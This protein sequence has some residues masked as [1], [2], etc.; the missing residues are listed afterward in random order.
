MKPLN[1]FAASTLL[2]GLSQG[3]ATNPQTQ[4]PAPLAKKPLEDLEINADSG[5]TCNKEGTH[6][7]ASGH[8]HVKQGA[9]E[10]TCHHLDVTFSRTDHGMQEVNEIQA[11][12]QVHITQKDAGYD[13]KAGRALYNHSNQTLDLYERPVLTQK[14]NDFEIM[15]SSHVQVLYAQGQAIAKGRPTVKKN[16]KLLQA[17]VLTM[18]FTPGQKI[19]HDG[20]PSR[21]ATNFDSLDA[22][23]DVILST[24]TDIATGDKGHYVHETQQGELLGNV[25]LAQCDKAI[26]GNHATFDM[27][28]GQAQMLYSKNAQHRV[29]AILAPHPKK[30]DDQPS[31]T[32]KE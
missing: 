18:H 30:T 11:R 27:Q 13:I 23:G 15:N 16:D 3:L 4:A 10:M 8:I 25:V 5:V 29:Q 22:E 26:Q 14:G 24:T 7:K 28:T 21:S 19:S 32:P 20:T 9:W 2:I 1:L 31:H 12:E 17:D 6:C